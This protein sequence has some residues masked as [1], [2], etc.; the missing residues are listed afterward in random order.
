MKKIWLA[1]ICVALIITMTACGGG[2]QPTNTDKQEAKGQESKGKKQE[3][4]QLGLIFELPEGTEEKAGDNESHSYK[5]EDYNVAIVPYK[6]DVTFTPDLLSGLANNVKSDEGIT[7]VT[8]A[9][10]KC[11]QL[12]GRGDN[13]DMTFLLIEAPQY[14]DVIMIW[15]DKSE[16]RDYHDFYEEFIKSIKFDDSVESVG[17]EE[18][19]PTYYVEGDTAVLQDCTIKITDYK[20]LK[21]GEGANAYG[22]NPVIVF[23]FDMTNN[24]QKEITPAVE[25]PLCVKVIQD[26][27]PNKVNELSPGVLIGEPAADTQLDKIKVGGTVGCAIS[28]ELTD[29]TTPVDVYFSNSAFSESVGSMQFK[30]N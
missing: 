9:G 20:I 14:Y 12:I 11:Y 3:Y 21:A 17:V 29:L 10:S 7:E 16:E 24:S 25:W 30:T 26:N 27:D 8:V 6:K 4:K 5:Y 28:Y 13:M 23:Y 19:K 22:K 2:E 15:K 18:Q 1:V